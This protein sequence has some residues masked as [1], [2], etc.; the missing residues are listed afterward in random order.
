MNAYE[1]Y[2][3]AYMEKN[4]CTRKEMYRRAGISP[5]NH[6]KYCKGTQ[7]LVSYAYKMSQLLGVAIHRLF[8]LEKVVNNEKAKRD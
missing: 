1:K 5:N 2:T 3:T 8:E 4:K 6:L 7:P